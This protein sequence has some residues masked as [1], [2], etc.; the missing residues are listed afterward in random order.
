MQNR[1][2][3]A[4]VSVLCL[5]TAGLMARVTSADFDAADYESMPE[6]SHARSL[7]AESRLNSIAFADANVGL[8]VGDRGTV[9][10]TE[11]GGDTWKVIE[12]GTL[13][14]LEAVTFRSSREAIAVGGGYDRVTGL[15]RGIVLVTDDGGRSW[16]RGGGD[17]P[18]LNEVSYERTNRRWIAKGDLSFID[19]ARKYE[20]SDHGRTWR[21]IGQARAGMN[22][23]DRLGSTAQNARR[24]SAWIRKTQSRAPMRCLVNV[25]DQTMMA[26]GD[27]GVILRSA[28]SGLTW[29]IVRGAG[30]ASAV[31]VVTSAPGRTPWQLIGI[32]TLEHHRRVSV[33][34]VDQ[35]GKRLV[36]D[37]AKTLPGRNQLPNPRTAANRVAEV[38][39]LHQ[40]ITS[41]G[42]AGVDRCDA[43]GPVT[44]EEWTDW[45]TAHSP[46]VLALDRTLPEDVQQR[47]LG[48]AIQNGVPRVIG[49]QANQRGDT[50]LHQNA[51]LPTAGVLAA[52][53]CGDARMWLAERQLHRKGGDGRLRGLAGDYLAIDWMYDAVSSV[54]RGDSIT[55]G[56]PI[57][58]GHRFESILPAASRRDLQVAQARSALTSKVDAMLAANHAG[59]RDGGIDLP[60]SLDEAFVHMESS[61]H[62]RSLM[63]WYRAT[64]AMDD[65]SHAR[66]LQAQILEQIA[67]RF[68]SSTAGKL[69]RLVLQRRATSMESEKLPKEIA[70]LVDADSANDVQTIT[71]EAPALSPFAVES[72]T[73]QAS[74]SMSSS[75]SGAGVSLTSG[76]FQPTKVQTNGTVKAGSLLDPRLRLDN[77]TQPTDGS[78]PSNSAIDLQ[79][80]F[81]PLT[82]IVDESKRRNGEIHQTPAENV[83]AASWQRLANSGASEWSRLLG[84]TGDRVV[85][86]PA[87]QSRPHLDGEL[88]DSIWQGREEVLANDGVHLRFAHD[89][90]FIYVAAAC[91]RMQTAGD[92]GDTNHR[93]DNDLNQAERFSLRL[94]VDQDLLTSFELEVTADRLTR[95]RI[96]GDP[97]WQPTWYVACKQ[98]DT[99]TQFEIAIQRSDLVDLPV[100]PLSDWYVDA[101]IMTPGERRRTLAMPEPQCWT[102]L[103]FGGR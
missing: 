19:L 71:S 17:L 61:S 85:F 8:A 73:Q 67:N 18:K 37:R 69:A 29:T 79:W 54:T 13:A 95:D 92:R 31:L 10:R 100:G 53:L 5:A 62:L 9:L 25:T 87:T 45:L 74:A 28:D 3:A 14:R 90:Q 49:F 89:D 97:A 72:Q 68:G 50:L 32:E 36:S 103:Q 76:L 78:S 44:D 70:S 82:L 42:G 96:N 20:S 41:I 43:G 40:A 98:S 55:S 15:S 2:T 12:S 52:D 94:D 24:F 65:S 58:T 34:W 48:L 22:R 27:H 101:S 30:R 51:M 35:A 46:M 33:L 86:S 11:D 83:P 23:D 16:Q 63:H 66:K 81:H 59:R 6:Y 102:T 21:G 75:P 26:A 7:R 93:R 38:D 47:L 99:A 39:R 64:E 4:I 88:D 60:Q 77:V 1:W 80:D 56:L 91:P 57:R 84:D